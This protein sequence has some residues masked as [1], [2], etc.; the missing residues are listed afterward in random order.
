MYEIRVDDGIDNVLF[1]VRLDTAAQ[2]L[3]YYDA[4]ATFVTF[5]SGI[6]LFTAPTLFHTGK[7]VVDPTTQRYVRL[8]LNHLAFDLGGFAPP[9]FASA[10]LAVL[11]VVVE[12]ETLAA[13]PTGT[14]V[15]DV[16]LTQ[17]EPA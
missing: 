5:A 14:Y 2:V 17:N 10:G 12:E 8:R 7:L 16:I 1:R 3:Q 4:T 13:V 9:V 6:N 11:T 15:D